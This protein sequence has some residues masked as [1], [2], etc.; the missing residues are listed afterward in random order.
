MSPTSR[1]RVRKTRGLTKS[2]EPRNVAHGVVKPRRCEVPRDPSKL[3]PN[4]TM[5]FYTV[6]RAIVSLP[7]TGTCMAWAVL[8]VYALQENVCVA[9]FLDRAHADHYCSWLIQTQQEIR[10][11]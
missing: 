4:P 1:A 5:V 9:M 6:N 10:G 8:R 2:F 7:G 11:A 3:D